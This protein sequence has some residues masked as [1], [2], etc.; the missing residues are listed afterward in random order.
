MIKIVICAENPVTRAGLAAM[1]QA[2]ATEVIAQ[3]S[4]LKALSRWL[5]S[6]RADL[7]VIEL[8]VLSEVEI[9]ELAQLLEALPAEE[10]LPVLLLL[11]DWLDDCLDDWPDGWPDGWQE[12]TADERRLIFQLLG[13]GMVSVLPMSVSAHQMRDAIAAITSGL[14]ILHPEIS[15]VLFAFN[16]STFVPRERVPPLTEPLTPREIQVLNQLAGGLTNKAIASALIISEHTVKFHISAI[17]SKLSA[18]GR[19]EA[20][21]IGIRLGI[22]ML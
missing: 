9:G 21:A 8:P 4:Q 12:S 20:V 7:A 17:L 11:D 3:V 22:V 18:S 16:S 14:T 1:A 13:T 10:T 19:T 15:E 6:Q 2:A 5:Q